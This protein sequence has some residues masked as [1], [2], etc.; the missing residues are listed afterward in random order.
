MNIVFFSRMSVFPVDGGAPRRI[1]G[2]ARAVADSGENVSLVM[3][4]P[5]E[6]SRRDGNLSILTY[7][8]DSRPFLAS[9]MTGRGL[10][11]RRGEIPGPV[12]VVQCE[13]PHSFPAVLFARGKLGRPPVVLDEHGVEFDFVRQAGLSRPGV[14]RTAATFSQECAAARLAAHIFTCSSVDSRRI[15]GLYRVPPAK[16]TDIPN[17]VGEEFL[18][19]VEPHRFGRPTVLFL[20][21]F[22][23]PP[24]V[25]AARVIQEVIAP[26]VSRQ[27]GSA[28]FVFVGGDQ[29]PWLSDSDHIHTTGYVADVRPLV[30]GADVCI[31]PIMQGS[32]T[33]LKILE[34][35]AL[36]KPVVSTAKGAEGIQVTGGSDIVIED[37]LQLFAE[38]VVRL[39]RD[40][41]EAQRLGLNARKLVQH[42]YTWKGAA[43]KAVAVYRDLAARRR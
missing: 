35:M 14:F 7:P 1:L 21:G 8:F 12:D 19:D 27:Q 15:S 16:M 11:R 28:Q 5:E 38:H 30:K 23:H 25:H 33:R 40:P 9:L 29:P 39:L 26:L 6:G 2:L 17:A 41:A 4:S 3:N 37:D 18:E 34:Y 31:A 24:N 36:G 13:F 42:E 22:R 10:A 20:G 32:G 43:R